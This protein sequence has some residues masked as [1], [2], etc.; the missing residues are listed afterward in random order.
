MEMFIIC[1]FLDAVAY[2]VSKALG[3][4]ACQVAYFNLLAHEFVI[5]FLVVDD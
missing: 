1:L 5:L 3:L 4:Y 2:L